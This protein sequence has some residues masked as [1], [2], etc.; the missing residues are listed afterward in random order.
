MSLC[1]ELCVLINVLTGAS[2]RA[3]SLSAVKYRLIV[4]RHCLFMCLQDSVIG[5]NLRL[6]LMGSA[7]MCNRR[8]SLMGSAGMCNRRLSLMGSAGRSNKTKKTQPD[9]IYS[10]V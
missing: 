10:R 8:L 9:V 2:V 3:V 4:T 6:S 5:G 7:G 1:D